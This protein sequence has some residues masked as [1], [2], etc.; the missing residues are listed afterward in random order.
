MDAVRAVVLAGG[1]ARWSD[2]RCAGVSVRDVQNAV[3]E[4]RVRHSGTRYV[5]PGGPPGLAAA[6]RHASALGCVS[7]LDH[8]G[9][10]LLVPPS[11]PHLAS[12]RHRE[13]R[14]VVWHRGPPCDSV[15][16]GP[17]RA[18]AEMG[19]CRPRV[20]VLVAL[21]A[22]T[23]S[24]LV[25]PEDV[26]ACARSRN[27]AGLQWALDHVDPRAESVIESAL[28]GHLLLAGITGVRLQV[29]LDGIGRVDLLIDDWLVV[30]A[31]GY[32]NHSNRTAYRNDRRRGVAGVFG[33]W[34]TLRFSY[35]DITLHADRVVATV[36][37]VLA[38]HR[39]GAF[40]TS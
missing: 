8:R 13:D 31:D 21:E 29:E 36:Q 3:R 6:A 37:A 7:A 17:E 39:R 32:E 18:L 30:E 5:L 23:R 24:G 33:G 9:F 25:E 14:R 1:I 16:V 4:G 19:T 35:E 15:A 38:R 20:E 28:R 34:V 12:S 2:L 40:R 27:R 11:V 10:P 22:A 26:L